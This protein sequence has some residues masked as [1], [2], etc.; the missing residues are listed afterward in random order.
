MGLTLKSCHRHGGDS[1]PQMQ[2]AKQ[3]ERILKKSQKVQ[4]ARKCKEV[5]V[6]CLLLAASGPGMPLRLKKNKSVSRGGAPPLETG[7]P[8]YTA[9]PIPVFSASN[10]SALA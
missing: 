8:C 3:T 1:W 4:D 10:S 9:G 6:P 7:P 5:P 2:S